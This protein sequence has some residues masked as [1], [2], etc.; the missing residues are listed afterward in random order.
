MA[1]SHD[2]SV[3]LAKTI[4][5]DAAASGAD[6]VSIHITHVPSYMAMHY[7]TGE[8]RVSEGKDAKPMYEYLDEISPS[9]DE[10]K[11][12]VETVRELKI[13]LMIMSNDKTCLDFSYELQ[14]DSYVILSACFDEYDFIVDKA[15]NNAYQ[16][17]T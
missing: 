14:P 8:G 12:V 2:G 6:G 16:G 1:Y 4:V 13:D 9:F 15:H 3:E 11:E 10:W 17:N 7:K 5:R